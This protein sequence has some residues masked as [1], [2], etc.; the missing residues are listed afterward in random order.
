MKVY[1][2]QSDKKM[3]KE[4]IDILEKIREKRNFSA[5]KYIEEKTELLNKYMNKS[6]LNACVI[7]ISGGIDSAVVLGIVNEAAKKQNSPIKKIIPMLLPIMGSTGVTNQSEATSRGKELC[8]KLNLKPYI[9]D[10]TSVNN[11]IRNALEPVVEIRGEDWA[12]G[13]LGPYSR[14][15][16]LYYTTSL[17]NQ[18]GY[19]AIVC[20]T[21]NRDEGTYL[22][23]IG[24]ASDGMVDLQIISDIHKSE[25]YQ[26]AKELEIPQSIINA[27]PSGDMYDSRSDEMVFGASYDFVELYLNYLNMTE[28]TKKEMISKLSEESK[29]QFNLYSKNLENLHRY[30]LH[31]Y[32]AKSPAVHLDLYDSSVKGGWDNYYEVTKKFMNS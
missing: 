4:L 3:N 28:E 27:V 30:N 19:G 11:E 23:Y 13:Q 22:G 20:G 21:T 26:I 31:K 18:A 6:K 17:L 8:K 9:I 14:T 1:N 10:L 16:I 32:I 12:I 5:K 2:E 7:A 15:P 29:E 24:K 25:V